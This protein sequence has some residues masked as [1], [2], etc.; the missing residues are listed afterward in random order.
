MPV[1][2]SSTLLCFVIAVSDGDTLKARCRATPPGTE[3][4][5]IVRLA[6]IDAPEHGQPYGQRAKKSLTEMALHKPVRLQCREKPDRYGRS[7]STAWAPPAPCT[8]RGCESTLDANLAM[9]TLGL[10]WWPAQFAREQPP[11]QRGQYEFAQ[12]EAKAKRVG[13]WREGGKPGRP[14]EWRREHR[15]WP[16]AR[17]A[18]GGGATVQ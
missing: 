10:A 16:H 7:L 6:G 9:L 4:T 17:A 5:R 18:T 1:L 12:D 11:Q 15:E 13:L 8:Q 2:A 3:T 14:G